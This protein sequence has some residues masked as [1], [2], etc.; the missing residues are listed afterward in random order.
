MLK[1]MKKLVTGGRA[2]VQSSMTAREAFSVFDTD[3]S[4]S[5][6]SDEL[7]EILLMG[8]GQSLSS[9]EVDAFIAEVDVNGDGELDVDEFEQMWKVW[10]AGAATKRPPPN[11]PGGAGSSASGSSASGSTASAASASSSS[12]S[13][14][15]AKARPAANVPNRANAGPKK[16]GSKAEADSRDYE[17][18]G[19]AP[20]GEWSAA[21]WLSALGISKIV[22]KALKVPHRDV[23]PAFEYIKKLKRSEV[24]TLLNDA[25]LGG[26]ADMLMAGIDA[27]SKQKVS[28]SA[29]LNDKFQASGKFQMSYGSLS[30]FYGGLESLLGPPQMH[31]DN[32]D[33]EGAATL[34][35]AMENEHC[36]S[37]DSL[38]AFDTSN[39]VTTHSKIEWEIVV[40]PDKE[41][42]KSLS[43]P[44]RVGLRDSHPQECRQPRSLEVMLEAMEKNANEQLRKA[45]HAEM[46]AEELLA[47]R[48]YTGPMYMKY[49]AVLRAKSGNVFLMQQNKA[50]CKGNDYPTSIH[51]TN[52]CVLKLSK[53]TKAGKV[54][55]GIK[56]AK[57]PKEF[58]VPNEMGVRGGIEYGFSSTTTD[59]SQ[60]LAYASGGGTG[61]AGEAM[62][63]FEMQMG[64]VDRGA[65]L[66]WLSQ[67]P[68]E[69]EVLLP[70]LT[71]IE[72]LTSDVEGSMLVI[73]S[74]L[75]LNLS[76]QTLEQVLSR[77]RKMLMDM[78]NGIELELREALSETVYPLARKILKKALEYGAY[79]N[80]PE[81]FNNDDNFAKVMQET[82]YLQ[83]TLI[84]E[85][86]HLKAAI[87]KSELIL[88]NW[89]ARGPAR[90]MLLAGWIHA[91]ASV[92]H[93]FIDLRESELSPDDGEQL[94]RLMSTCAKLTSID[95]RGNESIGERGA[96]ALVD[97]MAAAKVRTANSVP[98]SLNGVTHS[99]SQ[100]QIPKQ[101]S[102][103]DCRLL[104]A[105]LES[106]VF[107]EGVSAGM[108]DKGA[109]GTATLNRRGGSGSASDSWQPLMWAAKDNNMV[110]AEML[111]AKGHDV[112]KQESMQDKGLSGYSPLHWAAQKGHIKM[113]ELL[114]AHGANP[115]LLDK[116]SNSPKMLAVKK[117][118]H[119]VVA[120]LEAPPPK[121]GAA[122][123]AAGPAGA[124]VPKLAAGAAAGADKDRKRRTSTDAEKGDGKPLR[125]AR[126]SANKG[127]S[128]ARAGKPS[129]PRGSESLFAV[130]PSPRGKSGAKKAVEAAPA[131]ATKPAKDPSLWGNLNA[132][133]LL[134]S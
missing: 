66:T 24:E 74:R 130:K 133:P 62:T 23:Q 104:C 113:V 30:L 10:T 120:M 45:N 76:A 12:M 55:R 78:A 50:L 134:T 6:S 127:G 124:A 64:M 81:W 103:V 101:L 77:R 15:S 47:G 40:N 61:K 91:R 92:E 128:T 116:H 86:Q 31:K 125:S 72:A 5:I 33:P 110:V 60:A 4:G 14:P 114:L 59:K 42:I 37:V 121:P 19:D 71:G 108:G 49:N 79:S 48:L 105:E 85:I 11:K 26:L 63:I 109:K 96:N 56:D 118:E 21:K 7:K 87:D 129:T 32:K 27:L 54:W 89:K 131:N 35:K 126:G 17:E 119:E 41:K 93:V 1:N 57:L 69:R 8:T 36:N 84:N 51:A 38:D 100:L 3:G 46:I 28:S 68:F 132:D 29:A 53:L 112:N 117:G 52:S 111:I 83:R 80:P 58:W 123:G 20:E 107:A 99:R 122:A 16:A 65:D 9:A 106:N 75:S 34:L 97:F 82:L 13:V 44:E 98:R 22:T 25:N 90:I 73:H 70:P 2:G 67:Y 88:K 94:A 18:T 39:G 43:Y 95:V 102:V 115:N